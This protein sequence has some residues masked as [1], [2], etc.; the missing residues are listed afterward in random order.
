MVRS[1]TPP[2]MELKD[3]KRIALKAGESKTVTFNIDVNDLK[4][5]N[6]ALDYV[7]EPGEF[8]VMI[9]GNSLD[10]ESAKFVLK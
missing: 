1:V 6:S 7:A 4:F 8:T 9:G 2:V 10:V 5:F 3:Y